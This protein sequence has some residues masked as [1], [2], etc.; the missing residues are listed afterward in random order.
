MQSPSM[1]LAISKTMNIPNIGTRCLNHIQKKVLFKNTGAKDDK[2][3]GDILCQNGTDKRNKIYG[4]ILT[5]LM[6]NFG[7]NT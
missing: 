5:H 6:L 7:F 3:C 2:L 1:N 4:I